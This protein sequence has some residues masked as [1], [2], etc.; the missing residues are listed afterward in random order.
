[1]RDALALLP[2]VDVVALAHEQSI[3]AGGRAGAAAAGRARRGA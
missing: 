3:I 1:V 2:L